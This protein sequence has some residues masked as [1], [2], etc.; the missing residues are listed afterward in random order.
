MIVNDCPNWRVVLNGLEVDTANTWC[1]CEK[2][3]RLYPGAE[4]FNWCGEVLRDEQINYDTNNT[5]SRRP[6]SL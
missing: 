2:L 3:L 4:L 6:N 5:T 1:E